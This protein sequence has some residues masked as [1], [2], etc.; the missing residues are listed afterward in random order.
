MD[1]VKRDEGSKGGRK[2]SVW[3]REKRG[4]KKRREEGET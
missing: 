3:G 4:G 2:K 1:L